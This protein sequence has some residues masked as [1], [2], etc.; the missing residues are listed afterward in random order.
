MTATRLSC[1]RRA[2]RAARAFSAVGWA[3]L[4]IVPRGG[5]AH[6]LFSPPRGI[7]SPRTPLVYPAE[8]I[9]PGEIAMRYLTL[10]C[11]CLATLVGVAAWR[12]PAQRPAAPVAKGLKVH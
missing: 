4:L 6:C 5:P 12:C 9:L 1:L 2:A 3:F 7:I 8:D 10:A 11:L